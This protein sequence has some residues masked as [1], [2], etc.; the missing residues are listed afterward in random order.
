LAESSDEDLQRLSLYRLGLADGKLVSVRSSGADVAFARG[1][2][3]RD[4]R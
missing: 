2:V 4:L 3:E 1:D